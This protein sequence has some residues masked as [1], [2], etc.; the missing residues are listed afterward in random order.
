MPIYNGQ[1]GKTL[2][3]AKRKDAAARKARNKADKADV[4]KREAKLTKIENDGRFV[5]VEF[6]RN[7]GERVSAT[8]ELWAWNQPPADVAAADLEAIAQAS[9]PLAVWKGSKESGRPPRE[10]AK[11][12]QPA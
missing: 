2:A 5:H 1:W 3:E 12:R 11:S 7:N 8:Y 10:Q 4:R 6:T 9:V